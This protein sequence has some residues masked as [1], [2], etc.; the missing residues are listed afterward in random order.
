MVS[1]K[2][3]H[4][5]VVWAHQKVMSSKSASS[6]A[7]TDEGKWLIKKDETSLST[8]RDVQNDNYLESGGEMNRITTMK[9]RGGEQK[10]PFIYSTPWG[11]LLS[12]RTLQ[13]NLIPVCSLYLYSLVLTAFRPV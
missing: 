11:I 1:Y 9:V 12:R 3:P 8:S 5:S 6:A 10:D 4:Q 13:W 7:L 2:I